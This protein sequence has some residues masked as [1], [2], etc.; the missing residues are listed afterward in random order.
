VFQRTYWCNIG[1]TT[2]DTRATNELPLR[3]T[4]STILPVVFPPVIM[5]WRSFW[6]KAGSILSATATFVKGPRHTSVIFPVNTTAR[7]Q[8][9]HSFSAKKKTLSACPS[10]RNITNKLAAN[11]FSSVF[12]KVGTLVLA[13]IR[14][15][16][17]GW[18]EPDY[19]LCRLYH[20]RGPPVARGHPPISCQ[21]FTMLFWRL[22]VQ[23]TLKRITT[24]KKNRQLNFLGK[25]C[26]ATDK[27]ILASRT[28]KGPRLTLV[29]G[30]PNG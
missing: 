14:K 27:K 16:T 12:W 2:C 13:L 30:P 18:T 17:D 25:K 29:W 15:I 9:F 8:Q 28:R 11:E 23:C 26:T 6:P 21:I 24:T 20:V 4:C 3:H 7:F 5:H 19:P 22:N 1:R 10:M